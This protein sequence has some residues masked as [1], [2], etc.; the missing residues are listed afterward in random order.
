M[1]KIET[2]VFVHK[3]DEIL[4]AMKK[5]RFGEGRY[6]GFGGKKEEQ[7]KT[8]RDCAIRETE[9]EAK[10]RVKNLSYMG[11]ILF[12]FLDSEEDD[13][14]VHI[15]D[16]SEYEGDPEETEEMCP[17]WFKKNNMPYDEMWSADRYWMPLLFYQKKFVGEVHFKEEGVAYHNIEEVSTL[18]EVESS[19]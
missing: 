2:L 8:L 5:G 17:Q 3:E 9:E 19:T 18:E 1:V 14:E 4:L 16:T 12:K 11:R 15:Y 6:N 10:I 13:H 7:D